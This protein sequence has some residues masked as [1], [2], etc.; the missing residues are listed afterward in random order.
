MQGE[1]DGCEWNFTPW[2]RFDLRGRHWREPSWILSGKSLWILKPKRDIRAILCFSKCSQC[3]SW[4]QSSLIGRL[5]R[6]GLSWSAAVDFRNS[7][8]SPWSVVVS[9]FG[10]CS[11]CTASSV[12]VFPFPILFQRPFPPSIL[13]QTLLGL[14]AEFLISFKNLF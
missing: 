5:W 8:W 6:S 10:V 12:K 4:A 2:Y 1:L 14:Q 3:S 9:K 11:I 7:D 13:T